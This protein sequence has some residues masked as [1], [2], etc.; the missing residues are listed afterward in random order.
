M[1]CIFKQPFFIFKQYFTYFYIFFHPHVFSQIF[2]NNNFQYLNT[3]IKLAPSFR[4]SLVEIQILIWKLGGFDEGKIKN[5]KSFS[6]SI[7]SFGALSHHHHH[8]RLATTPFHLNVGNISA[9][10]RCQFCSIF[11]PNFLLSWPCLLIIRG[12]G[13]MLVWC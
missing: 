9:L 3:C 7:F 10:V 13:F 1:V 2:S 6:F 12:C 8:H 4:Y 5:K 11:F